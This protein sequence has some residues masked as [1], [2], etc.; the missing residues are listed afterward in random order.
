MSR[1]PLA[2]L[3]AVLPALPAATSAG[4]DLP[5][6][7][8]KTWA[9]KP[10]AQLGLDAAKLDRL[11][12]LMGGRGCVVRRGHLVYSWG[13]VSRS[14]DVASA[15]K[16]VFVYFLFKAIEEGKIPSLDSPVVRWEPR[17]DGLNAALPFKDRKIT[18]RH[19]ASQTSCYGVQESPGTAYDYSDFNMALLFDTL[20]EKVYDVSRDQADAE[21]LRPR[22]T[23]LLEC[24]DRPT[25]MVF[26]VE[27]RPGRLGISV[28]D[29]ARFGLLY[30]R[31]GQ[32]NG[33][34]IIPREHALQAV[35]SPVVA[36]VPRTQGKA[37]EMIPG[38]RS[39]G[40]KN[41]Q[42]DHLGS[43]SL[44]WWIN[45][46]DRDGR[47]HWPDVPHDAFAALGHGGRRGLAVIPSLD[48]VLSWNDSRLNG[49][50]TEDRALEALVRCVNG[51]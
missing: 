49:P 16:P 25:L 44:A 40:G 46:V 30:L 17:L 26:G 27:D 24:E 8:G 2:I 34:Q 37:A 5:V 13:D 19:L 50:E 20:M 29:F 3:I 42:T 1:A 35:T 36:A 32:W 38:Q 23:E 45:G 14:A 33:K 31:Q 11:R 12:D 21:V 10:P 39:L 51:S 7:P 41:N 4:T 15:C 43:Y 6:F 22:L 9:V 47:R 18:W 28:R 48:L